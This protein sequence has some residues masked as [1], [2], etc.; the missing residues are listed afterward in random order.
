MARKNNYHFARFSAKTLDEESYK[1]SL[2]IVQRYQKKNRKPGALVK[3]IPNLKWHKNV[4]K[5]YLN[6]KLSKKKKDKTKNE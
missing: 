1:Q 4:L 2:K 6:E 5:T 3:P